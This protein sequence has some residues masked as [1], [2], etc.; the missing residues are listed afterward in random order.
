MALLVPETHSINVT[1]LDFL[2]IRVLVGGA[3]TCTLR[4]TS[5]S[6]SVCGVGALGAF[7][8]FVDASDLSP[9]RPLLFGRRVVIV[10]VGK[11]RY[12][13]DFDSIFDCT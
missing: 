10:V 4:I 12:T 3:L 2:V 6:A 5:S 9:Y 8:V 1:T 7:G 11:K 13:S